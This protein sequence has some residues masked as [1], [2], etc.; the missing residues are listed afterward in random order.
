[1]TVPRIA[2]I[3]GGVTGL[4]AAWE[5]RNDA[6]VT[7]FEASDRL[8]GKVLTQELEGVQIEAGPDSLL[9]RDDEPVRLLG[10]L[11]LEDEV[12]EP[13]DFGAW[14]AVNGRLKRLPD[15]FVL[16]FPASPT[17]VARS[18]LLSP[19][20]TLRAAA[21]LVLPRSHVDD[22]VSVG[23]LVRSRFGTEVAERIVAPLMSGVRS[24]RIDEMSLEMAAP[25]IATAAR[26][27]R[28]V[29]LGLRKMAKNAQRPRF[30]GLR[31]GMASLIDGLHKRSAA[32]I[33]L[34]TP[35][36]ALEEDLTLAGRSFDGVVVAIPPSVAATLLA[37]EHL[38]NVRFSSS[39]VVNAVY[40]PGAVPLPTSGTGI[41]V[42]DGRALI[43]CT[44]VTKKWLHLAPD[45]GRVL[46]RCI[47]AAHVAADDV[48]RELES[49]VGVSA[50][51][52]AT[53]THVWHTAL[54]KFTVGHRRRIH[55]AAAALR[56]RPVRFAGAGYLAT[57]INDCLAQG[58]EAAREV[59]E[60][61]R[62]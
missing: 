26:T 38:G 31:R 59:L 41:L 28:S 49:L 17:A 11:G 52:L 9:A 7:V 55:A 48:L 37:D 29:T 46:I 42:A 19:L 8:G 21:D 51:P 10:E 27:H 56:R 25:Q 13:E 5:L 4:A 45:D 22:D 15:G 57:G 58:R 53:K 12:V 16:G 3:G 40:P 62:P 23:R 44:W 34:R 54:P 6:A 30:L 32:E 24:G 33:S 14:I 18:G 50:P 39:M 47:G 35:I 36:E 20:G 2:V 60:V 1:V 43:A 61:A